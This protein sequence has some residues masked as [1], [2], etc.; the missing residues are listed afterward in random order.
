MRV[1]VM[2][3][4]S[5]DSEGGVMPSQKLLAE[6]GTFK[7]GIDESWRVSWRR[8]TASQLEGQARQVSGQVAHGDRRP[9]QRNQRTRGLLL[10]VAGKVHGG[11]R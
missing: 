2:V 5:K 7:P 9:L 10:V 3:K 4:A 6:M 11:G 1:M 8:R